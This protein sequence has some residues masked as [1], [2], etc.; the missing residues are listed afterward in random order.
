MIF[1]N[2]VLFFNYG[3]GKTEVNKSSSIDSFPSEV[4]AYETLGF[5]PE[6]CTATEYQIHKKL[7]EGY[8][9]ME[10]IFDEGKKSVEVKR[11]PFADF[12]K[13]YNRERD[14]CAKTKGCK[15]NPGFSPGRKYWGWARMIQKAVLKITPEVLTFYPNIKIH[16][17]AVIVPDN[18]SI[19]DKKIIIKNTLRE[20]DNVCKSGKVPF[21]IKI[22]VV[23][24]E[25]TDE[26]F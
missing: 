7:G 4:C 19:K 23:F 9:V 8:P 2:G 12:N 10:A 21:K 13:K 6:D 16:Y 26:M 1:Q 15:F 18:M 25:G 3:A 11:I 17:I 22:E 24:I 14:I 5:T 20:V